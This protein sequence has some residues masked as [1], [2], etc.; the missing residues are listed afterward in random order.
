[1]KT[2]AAFLA[3][4]LIA[5]VSLARAQEASPEAAPVQ[6]GPSISDT[7]FP[8]TPV[9]AETSPT[10]APTS[11]PALA[12]AELPTDPGAP[13]LTEPA[14]TP[15]SAAK[16]GSSEQLRQNIR[17]R[18]LKTQVLADPEVE[19]QLQLAEKAKTEEG[20]RTL[21][22][23]HYALL[24]TKMEKLDPSLTTVLET[25]LFVI[26]KGLEQTQVRPTQLTEKVVALPG[27]RSADH[28]PARKQP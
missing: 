8:V 11:T 28:D 16:K 15:T 27:S 6:I 5:G 7:L 9:P 13:S 18:E 2:P 10:P 12:P 25:Q 14:K 3:A 20:R 22:R 21:L 4:L 17:I 26:L 19:A 23:N 1:M 24:Y